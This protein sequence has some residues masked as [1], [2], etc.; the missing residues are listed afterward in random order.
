MQAVAQV[1]VGLAAL[2]VLIGAALQDLRERLIDNRFSLL[3]LAIGCARHAVTA[4]DWGQGLGAALAAVAAALAVL[5]VGYTLWRLGGIGGG[6]VKLLVAATFLVG[7]DGI[8]VLLAGTALAGGG[9]ALVCLLAP[10]V[11]TRLA[12]TGL[13][14]LAAIDT[15]ARPS[16]PYGV[17]IAAGGAWALVP[18]LPFL[19][20]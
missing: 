18:A 19:F 6:D 15:G 5:V 1:I 3:L 13:L 11:A 12:A 14:P 16:V 7:V 2:T 20:G 9:L 17:A 10:F 8:A 4:D